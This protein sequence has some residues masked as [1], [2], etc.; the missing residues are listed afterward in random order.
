M[1][2]HSRVRTLRVSGW[3]TRSPLSEPSRQNHRH[4]SCETS[5]CWVPLFRY[6]LA[7][8]LPAGRAPAPDLEQT[9]WVQRDFSRAA[10]FSP[11]IPSTRELITKILRHT[12]RYIFCRSDQKSRYDFDSFTPDGCCCVTV[13]IVL[14]DNLRGK[15]SASLAK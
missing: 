11:F 13:V 12:Q 14:F 1:R 5:S 7:G 2:K 10:L 3:L 8:I 6:R 15:R 9:M 4:S